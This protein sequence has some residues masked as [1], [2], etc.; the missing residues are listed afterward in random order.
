[1]GGCCFQHQIT[2]QKMQYLAPQTLGPKRSQILK[3]AR[4][5]RFI[6]SP[7]SQFCPRSPSEKGQRGNATLHSL[8]AGPH[9]SAV[10]LLMAASL[11][12]LVCPLRAFSPPSVLVPSR[13]AGGVAWSRLG[14]GL[15][16]LYACTKRQSLAERYLDECNKM[17]PVNPELGTLVLTKVHFP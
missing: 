14:C 3:A 11:L 1:M 8:A 5:P 13:A 10:A 16:S 7:P 12:A 4:P 2:A 9:R 15:V 17:R 6:V